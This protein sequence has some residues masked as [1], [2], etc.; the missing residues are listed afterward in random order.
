MFPAN[1]GTAEAATM[2]AIIAAT[3]TSNSM[4]LKRYLLYLLSSNP[5]WVANHLVDYDYEQ[6]NG[7]EGRGGT[8]LPLFTQLPTETVWKIDG[9]F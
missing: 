8:P 2:A 4:R 3:V 1:A 5:R 7:Q 9:R 6:R